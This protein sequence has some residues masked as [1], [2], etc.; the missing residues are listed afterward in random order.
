M[1]WNILLILSR[2][3]MCRNIDTFLNL[4]MCKLSIELYITYK[5]KSINSFPNL[6]Q[7]STLHNTTLS[8]FELA[9]CFNIAGL[10]AVL[11]GN[12]DLTRA[13]QMVSVNHIPTRFF[14]Y[15]LR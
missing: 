7:N 3:Q 15:D 1:V 8:I 11:D 14:L 2:K 13:K 9:M 12:Q 5:K 10:F 6:P 4:Y